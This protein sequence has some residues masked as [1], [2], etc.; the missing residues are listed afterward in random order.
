ML[1]S[2]DHMD[3]VKR[4]RV[5]E[6]DLTPLIPTYEVRSHFIRYTPE[7]DNYTESVGKAT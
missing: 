6:K 4:M 7:T 3:A 1:K 2:A 5:S